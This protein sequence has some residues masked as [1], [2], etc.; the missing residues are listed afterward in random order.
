MSKARLVIT[1]VLIEG[2]SQHEVARA[3]GV[4]QSW[5]SRLVARYRHE[6][7]LAFQPRSRRPLRSPRGE[8]PG[9]RRAHPSCLLLAAAQETLQLWND[10][11]D[12]SDLAED[13]A[14]HAR[15]ALQ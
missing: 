6:G 8:L 11:L 7:E 3:Y 2:R 9:D 10:E 14:L 1:A 5:I 15:L 4:S 12:Y 13:I